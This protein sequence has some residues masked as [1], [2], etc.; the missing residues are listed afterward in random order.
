MLYPRISIYMHQEVYDALESFIMSYDIDIS[1]TN[2]IRFLIT[3]ARSFVEDDV[4]L[5]QAEQIITVLDDS[6]LSSSDMDL[7][8]KRAGRM[9]YRIGFNKDMTEY[10]S[11]QL[12][13]MLIAAMIDKD[14][15]L[16]ELGFRDFY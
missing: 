14:I 13:E 8:C 4:F 7:S 9:N 16:D 15:A 6:S 12:Y 1:V 2:L 11:D 3:Y 5:L 10:S